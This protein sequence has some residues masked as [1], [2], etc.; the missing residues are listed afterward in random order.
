[1]TSKI[2]KIILSFLGLCLF[3]ICS[4][5]LP[6]PEQKLNPAPLLSL[7]IL[8]REGNL[9]REVLSDKGGRCRWVEF[10]E[11]SSDLVKATIAALR[12]LRPKHE[13]ERLRGV[14]LS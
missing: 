7:R 14:N 3:F 11:V 13:V 5:Y 2:K 12:Q 1:M 10:E 8:D 9:L 6:I 4:L